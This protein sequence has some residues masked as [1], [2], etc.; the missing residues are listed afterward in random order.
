MSG[1]YMLPWYE[2]NLAAFYNTRSGYPYIRSVLSP[3]RPF[4]AGTVDVFLDKRGDVV[5]ENPNL[6]LSRTDRTRSNRSNPSRSFDRRAG[7]I[8]VGSGLP[9]QLLGLRPLQSVEYEGSWPDFRRNFRPLPAEF[10]Q[11]PSG[12][13]PARRP[14]QAVL[15]FHVTTLTVHRHLDAVGAPRASEALAG[16]TART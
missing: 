4:S 10:R 1:S 13:Y 5:G 11:N 12:T 14:S 7:W 16:A 6:E 3:T 2:I 9:N 8:G 15:H